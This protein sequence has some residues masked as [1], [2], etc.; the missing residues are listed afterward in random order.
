MKWFYSLGLII[1][2][3]LPKFALGNK[4]DVLVIESYHGGYAWDAS[5]IQGLQEVLADKYN[6]IFF[7]MNTKRLREDQFTERASLAW[8]KYKEV[9]PE[10]VILGDDNALKYLGPKFLGTT[11]PVV[12]LGIN[13]NP[14]A[15]GMIGHNNI[16]GVLERPLLKRSILLL[17]KFYNADKVLVLFDSSVTAKIVRTERFYNK[18]SIN[19]G[20]IS[21]EIKLMKDFNNWKKVVKDS[22]KMGYDMIIVGLYHTLIDEN[23]NHIAAEKIIKWTSE[24]TPIPAYA[25]WDFTV[26][27]DKSIGG[28]VLVGKHQ[29]IVAGNIALKILSGKS[30]GTIFPVAAEKGQYLFSKTQLEKWNITLPKEVVDMSTFKE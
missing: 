3:F 7:E 26:G 14:R 11:T 2:L 30:P 15:Y 10:L 6:L 16:T 13:N 17:N 23:G 12:Y 4:P 5:Y 22:Q 21:V 20:G 25:F 19:L 29:G 1:V 8:Q 18:D 27:A 9:E 24:N 28:Y